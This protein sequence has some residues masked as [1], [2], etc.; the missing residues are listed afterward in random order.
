M[1]DQMPDIP[2][3]PPQLGTMQLVVLGGSRAY[4]LATPDS[5]YDFKGTYLA[6][7]E[8]ILGLSPVEQS[9]VQH[10][11]DM[12]AHELA[13]FC[14]LALAAN[15]TIL[16]VMCCEPIHATFTGQWLI[17][18]VELFF[19]NR[20]RVTFGGYARQ[21]FSRLTTRGDGSFSADTRKRT[22]KHARHLRSQ[23]PRRDDSAMSAGLSG[24]RAPTYPT[25]T[26]AL[27]HCRIISG[28]R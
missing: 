26:N 18:N 16:E 9:W 1:T 14:S 25:H 19:S 2:Q 17:D 23:P 10:E 20:V 8:S 7:I 6:P 24:S 3:L 11:P 28:N 15:P 12:Q 27:L 4:G 13:K 21:Q 22:E 5:D